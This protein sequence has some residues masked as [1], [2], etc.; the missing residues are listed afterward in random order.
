M[1]EAILLAIGVKSVTYSSLVV[2][3]ALRKPEFQQ[4]VINL[5]ACEGQ[6]T[7]Y[8]TVVPFYNLKSIGNECI[9]SLNLK[10]HERILMKFKEMSTKTQG[11]DE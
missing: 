10:S 6:S 1:E 9:I 3:P 7:V 4:E 5:L 2:Q 8:Q 11:R